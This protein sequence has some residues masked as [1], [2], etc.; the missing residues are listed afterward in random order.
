VQSVNPLSR[1]PFTKQTRQAKPAGL[2]EKRKP[3]RNQRWSLDSRASAT[4]LWASPA[5]AFEFK[6]LINNHI[7]LSRPSLGGSSAAPKNKSGPNY[8][9]GSRFCVTKYPLS[10]SLGGEYAFEPKLLIK[11][12]LLGSVESSNAV[13]TGRQARGG[14]PTRRR[15]GQTA[16]RAKNEITKPFPCLARAVS[17]R[18]FSTPS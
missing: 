9:A 14:L 8:G 11:Q 16:P 15:R 3:S 5:C 10:N 18:L 13:A 1:R 12:D 4:G 7:S 6:L 17:E 2:P